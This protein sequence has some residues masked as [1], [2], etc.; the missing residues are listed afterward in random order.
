MPAINWIV[1]GY[2][3]KFKLPSN[4]NELGVEEIMNKRI[5]FR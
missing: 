5:H 4:R 2:L 1:K 3:A